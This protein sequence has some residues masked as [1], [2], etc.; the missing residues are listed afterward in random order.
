MAAVLSAGPTKA[1]TT[2]R[3]LASGDGIELESQVNGK[4]V[5]DI[6]PVYR[7]G[8]ARYFAAG[9]GLQEREAVYPPFSLK[10]VF[11]AG[12]KPY[13]TG[14][15][16]TIRDAKGKVRVKIPRDHVTGPWL[17]VDLPPG[18]YDIESTYGG[19]TQSLKKIQ[20]ESGKTKTIYLRWPEDRAV[21][22]QFPPD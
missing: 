21:A 1:G 12:G 10:L 3:L 7:E 14:V 16:V 5:K 4:T 8:G 11:T 9:V 22:I 13:L 17:F 20:V 15:P 19:Q 2:A 18:V 6:L